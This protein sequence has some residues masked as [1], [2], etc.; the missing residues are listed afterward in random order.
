M[1]AGKT[2]LRPESSDSCFLCDALQTGDIGST[3]VVGEVGSDMSNM[4]LSNMDDRFADGG[5][6]GAEDG[7]NSD[8]LSDTRD[9]RPYGVMEMVEAESLG[10]WPIKGVPSPR[11]TCHGFCGG[12]GDDGQETWGGVKVPEVSACLFFLGFLWS[13]L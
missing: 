1:P 6:L 9:Q 8:G 7:A 13:G 4:P 10:V 11:P 5:E 3:L 2:L 12:A